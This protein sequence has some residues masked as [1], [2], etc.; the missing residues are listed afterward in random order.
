M[1]ML[2][3][4]YLCEQF[5]SKTKTNKFALRSK[6]TD[7]HLESVLRLAN[8]REFESNTHSLAASKRCQMSS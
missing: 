8:L 5:C 4:T 6:L 2:G 3:N 7:D 1:A